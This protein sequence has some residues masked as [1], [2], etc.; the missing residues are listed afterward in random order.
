MGT[1]S[2]PQVRAAVRAGRGVNEPLV[3]LQ[4]MTTGHSESPMASDLA[5]NAT[6]TASGWDTSSC[7]T[8]GVQ[9]C[10]CVLR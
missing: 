7:P 9:L 10:F 3:G 1:H 2:M 6:T 4:H 5:T 8:E